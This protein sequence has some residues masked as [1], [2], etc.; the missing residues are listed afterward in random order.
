MQ[1]H[2]KI[3]VF[4]QSYADSMLEEYAGQTVTPSVLQEVSKVVRLS[5]PA[6]KIRAKK[7]NI[8]V[9]RAW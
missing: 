9:K 4:K 6:I 7:L 3:L 1:G 5:Y 2:A 8:K